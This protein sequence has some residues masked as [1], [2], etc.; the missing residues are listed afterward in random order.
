MLI[1]IPV[2][3]ENKCYVN[4]LWAIFYLHIDTQWHTVTIH[5]LLFNAFN[6]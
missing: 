3:N 6:L 5:Q 1:L 2:I 4:N